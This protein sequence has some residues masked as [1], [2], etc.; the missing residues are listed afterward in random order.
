MQYF[1]HRKTGIF[2]DYN[3]TLQI[4]LDDN[5]EIWWYSISKVLISLLY[6]KNYHHR[7]VNDL[8]QHGFTDRILDEFREEFPSQRRAIW[9]YTRSGIFF[10][11]LNR[12]FRQRNL[13]V[14]L[15]FGSF[16]Q[17]L[18]L[19]LKEEQSKQQQLRSTN[20]TDTVYRGQAIS[21]DDL[22]KLAP[23]CAIQNMT[24]LSTS[25]D[26]EKAEDFLLSSVGMQNVTRVI[27]E[28]DIDYEHKTA[29][30]S[31]MAQFSF[32][33]SEC[34]VLFIMNTRFA[35]QS[36]E[37]CNDRPDLPPHWV[38][39]LK[40]KSYYDMLRDRQLNAGPERERKTLKNCLNALSDMSE[41]IATSEDTVVF[42]ILM[43]IYPDE[44]EWIRA[45]KLSCLAE[46]EAQ[47]CD[48]PRENEVDYSLAFPI[49]EQSLQIWENYLHDDQLNCSFDI[50]LIY[51][52]MAELYHCVPSDSNEHY[53]CYLKKA[54]D[55]Y[56]IALNKCSPMDYEEMEI[57]YNLNGAY[58]NL[59][60]IDP[61]T[62]GLK[63]IRFNERW[64]ELQIH[65]IIPPKPKD[66]AN[67]YEDLAKRYEMI[68]HYNDA[69][70]YYQKSLELYLSNDLDEG[71][72]LS[73]RD[74]YKT[75][76]KIYTKNT[77][78]FNCAL[79]YDLLRHQ[80]C[81]KWLE[82]KQRPFSEYHLHC[83]ADSHFFVAECYINTRELDLAHQHLVEGLTSMR[84]RKDSIVEQ[85][86]LVFRN[87]Q[88]VYTP[89]GQF[90]RQTCHPN[91][92]YLNDC[93]S[94]IKEKEKKLKYVEILLKLS[95]LFRKIFRFLFYIFPFIFLW[96]NFVRLI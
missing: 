17:D 7:L 47:R 25:T 21:E 4:S 38:I 42:D 12:A 36:R 26:R 53:L 52:A 70:N 86:Q 91:N 13:K 32:F 46:F 81:L 15:L 14:L 10:D 69:L 89:D 28:I 58:F 60:K 87:G 72:S 44:K 16:V 90:L 31:D 18:Y 8:K 74:L 78:D 84:Q 6:P 43:N 71:L 96:K 35:F 55:S 19:H 30:F 79:H 23:D 95:N 68:N 76:V 29:L 57:V 2:S 65:D 34:E 88:L 40:L 66:I 85:G 20:P 93:L 82:G 22:E 54:V 49:Y 50:A 77:H 37:E 61:N 39:K 62:Y 64:I 80:F 27:F 41:L 5:F 48:N 67:Q 1:I 24:F 83:L 59:T 94:K 11:I 9:W 75:I 3:P 56:E 73:I 51:N 33:P 45:I 63:A 92:Q